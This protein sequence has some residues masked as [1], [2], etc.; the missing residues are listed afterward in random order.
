VIH[1]DTHVVVRL[2]AGDL[3]RFSLA[4]RRRLALLIEIL[5]SRSGLR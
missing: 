2:Y 1:L 5:P 3:R 4:S